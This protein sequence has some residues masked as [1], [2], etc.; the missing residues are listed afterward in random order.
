MRAISCSP[1][2]R[3]RRQGGQDRTGQLAYG[4]HAVQVSQGLHGR[5][6]QRVEEGPALFTV[7][8]C[9][10]QGAH[11]LGRPRGADLQDDTEFCLGG[12]R[13][14]LRLQAEEQ[15]GDLPAE[16]A[17]CGPACSASSSAAATGSGSDP[18]VIPACPGAPRPV[19]VAANCLRHWV[20][21]AFTSRLVMS[22]TPDIRFSR[23][24]ST[25]TRSAT[26]RTPNGSRADSARADRPACAS[27]V[28]G[29]ALAALSSASSGIVFGTGAKTACQPAQH[30]GRGVVALGGV[31]GQGLAEEPCQRPG[32]GRVEHV[33]L[34][35]RFAGQRG[36]VGQPV[37]V[38]RRGAG[39]HLEQH[40]GGGVP[41]RGR[42]EPA[43]FGS[44]E[45]RV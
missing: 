6:G 38:A 16:L 15:A 7:R 9:L 20:A 19:T 35:G 42:V 8:P 23:T 13:F 33:R 37:A 43:S 31:A 36:G 40:D 44:A 45:E 28:S 3:G 4:S 30:I 5:C 11:L 25:A 29:V 14:G 12:E 18:A 22:A 17:R 32:D 41:L 10:L 39:G 1:G 24:G 21:R 26:V 34:D 2:R 27:G